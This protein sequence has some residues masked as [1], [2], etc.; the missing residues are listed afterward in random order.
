MGERNHFTEQQI[1]RSDRRSD[2]NRSKI[3]S[4]CT[5]QAF[6]VKSSNI[7]AHKISGEHLYR[8]KSYGGVPS[9]KFRSRDHDHAHFRGQFVV[10]WLEH[11]VLDECTKYEVSICNR[12]KNTKWVVKNQNGSRDLNHSHS[13]VKFLS[14]VLST[15][16]ARK[17]WST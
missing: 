1:T 15:V 13:G 5:E 2:K 10:L 12:S 7:L 17:I 16:L 11:I 9:F 8:Y 14:P 3:W 4:S 6:V